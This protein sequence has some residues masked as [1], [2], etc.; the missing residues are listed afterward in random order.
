MSKTL[1]TKK[2]VGLFGAGS[3]E[4]VEF[5]D[6]KLEHAQSGSVW[7]WL[8]GIY[9]V[10]QYLDEDGTLDEITMQGEFNEEIDIIKEWIQEWK[11]SENEQ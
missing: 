7:F 4:L 9:K 6:K 11:E 3:D 10:E 2:Q 1:K 5:L 8:Q